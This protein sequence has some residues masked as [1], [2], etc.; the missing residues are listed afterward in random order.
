MNLWCIV[1]EDELDLTT[2][3][4]ESGQV[5]HTIASKKHKIWTRM[6]AFMHID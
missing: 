2:V 4:A 5:K 6:V 1:A 3:K